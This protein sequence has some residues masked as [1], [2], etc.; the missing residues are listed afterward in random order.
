MVQTV[1]EPS[2]LQ[3]PDGAASPARLHHQNVLFLQL[4]KLIEIY[5]VCDGTTLACGPFTLLA[6]QLRPVFGQ[7][8]TIKPQ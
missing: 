2:L 6:D 7:L 4:S 1:A 3:H 5:P 8:S